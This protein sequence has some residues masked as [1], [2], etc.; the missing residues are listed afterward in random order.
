MDESLDEYSFGKL[1]KKQRERHKGL[2]Q[3]ALAEKMRIDR[4]STI[5]DWEREQQLP[6]RFHL[7]ELI[8]AL[9]LN[10]EDTQ[11]FKAAYQHAQGGS[12]RHTSPE[13]VLPSLLNVPFL[14]NP[15]FTGR[16]QLLRQLHSALTE[17]K[18]IA[19]VQAISGLG[20]I[21]KTQ[22]ALEYVYRFQQSYQAILWVN[23]SSQEALLADIVTLAQLLD[24][25]EKES[26]EQEIILG[27]VKHWLKV[28]TNW[29]LVLDNADD[30]LL[31]QDLLPIAAT[32]HMLLTTRTQLV[33]PV[34]V[35]M[36]IAVMSPREGSF[37]LLRRCGW[38]ETYKQFVH[39]SPELHRVAQQ[40]VHELGGLPLALNQAGAYIHETGSDLLHYL[41]LYQKQH[42]SLLE[43]RYQPSA[44]YPAS[45]ATTWS[46]SFQRVRRTNPRA[47]EV[48]T[49]CAFLHPDAIPEAVFVQGAQWPDSALESPEQDVFHE[50]VKDLRRFSLLDWSPEKKTLSIHR[51]VQVVLKDALDE[52]STRHCAEWAVL[53]V[54][55]AFPRA[56]YATLQQCER[57]LPQALTVTAYIEPY[58]LI[59]LEAGRLCYEI[60]RHLM[61]RAQYAEVESLYQLSR[62]TKEQLLGAE[63]PDTVNVAFELAYFYQTQGKHE[64]AEPL[65]LWV[66]SIYEQQLGP[67][68]LTTAASLRGLAY[69]YWNLGKYAQAEPLSLRALSIHEQQLG[70]GHLETARSLNNLAATYRDMGEYARAEPLYLRALSI[71]EEQLGPEH[72]DTATILINIVVLY[73]NQR[74]Y[75]EAESLVKRCLAIREQQLGG[76]H[77]EVAVCLYG[78]AELYTMQGKYARAEALFQRALRIDEQRLG[79]E[80]VTVAY[81]LNGLANLHRTQR[82]YVEAEQ[83]YQRALQ[84]ATHHLGREHAKTAEIMCD[85]AVLQEAQGNREEARAFYQQALVIYQQTHGD[86]HPKTEETRM[87]YI[88]LLALM[89]EDKEG[90]LPELRTQ[91]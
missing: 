38:L 45:V 74:R 80:H 26:R 64:Q 36:N 31:V 24:L 91:E 7:R 71:N 20:G 56:E 72:L 15:L 62:R 42:L 41:A 59:N 37:F 5:S 1:L 19:L 11:L 14:R 17:N 22:A 52:T 55:R 40:I 33:R 87:R 51:L 44:E 63:H 48:L 68:H 12:T 32:G 47:A 28:H 89:D 60:G 57:L 3:A 4:R 86:A 67:E 6:D 39:L 8:Q 81:P 2:T 25:P 83:L 84:I 27:A 23:A 75:K 30:L 53:A 61:S 90:V 9:G 78:L 46:L 88:T 73:R 77:P 70:P 21:G 79:A 49:L 66:L 58:R 43:Q 82:R 18:T 65:Y 34:A 54:S 69:F 29:L 76:E 85:M 35:P 10:E 16:K 50:A 13:Q